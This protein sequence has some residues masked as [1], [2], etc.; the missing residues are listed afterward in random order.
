MS[1]DEQ[2]NRRRP[3]SVSDVNR[4]TREV[5]IFNTTTITTT[6][7]T[8]DSSVSTSFSNSGT[9]QTDND[10][11]GIKIIN[12]NQI[13]RR[14][15]PRS[16]SAFVSSTSNTRQEDSKQTDTSPNQNISQTTN[17][18]IYNPSK[19]KIKFVYGDEQQN[20]DP[21]SSVEIKYDNSKKTSFVKHDNVRPSLNE[22][23]Y[24]LNDNVPAFPLVKTSVLTTTPDAVISNCVEINKKGYYNDT[25]DNCNYDIREKEIA[26]HMRI[27]DVEVECEIDDDPAIF[28]GSE[29]YVKNLISKIQQQYRNPET[30]HIKIIRRQKPEGFDSR[31]NLIKNDRESYG[32]IVRKEYYTVKSSSHPK[33]SSSIS[34][35]VD[36]SNIPYIDDELDS[37]NNSVRNSRVIDY[38]LRGHKPNYI[39]E[40]HII[41]K[42][43][44]NETAGSKKKG[45]NRGILLKLKMILI[46]NNLY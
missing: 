39:I 45:K 32:Q 33:K 10:N 28:E 37:R 20:I 21:N 19:R 23:V 26:G 14:G 7:R 3:F 36:T 18:S 42:D 44:D 16:K 35:F 31:G 30:V 40:K 46:I 12:D 43:Q 27:K 6:T 25:Y 2:E 17:T 34:S 5:K 24:Y 1:A 13:I 8:H 11:Y 41:Y 15:D 29:G 38:E 22:N 9:R 4:R